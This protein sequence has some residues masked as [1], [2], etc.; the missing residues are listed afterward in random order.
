MTGHILTESFLWRN[1]DLS[2]VQVLLKGAGRKLLETLGESKQF[3]PLGE[4]SAVVANLENF[5]FF[6]ILFCLKELI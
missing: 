5:F 4:R 2:D 3:F 6:Y 1:A